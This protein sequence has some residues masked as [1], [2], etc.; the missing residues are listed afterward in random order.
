MI[1]RQRLRISCFAYSLFI[2]S[3][4][5]LAG[6]VALQR[7]P[8]LQWERYGTAAVVVFGGSLFFSRLRGPLSFCPW[9]FSLLATGDDPILAG[10]PAAVKRAGLAVI[11]L[12]KALYNLMQKKRGHKP[13]NGAGLQ[14]GGGT[15]IR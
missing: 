1:S 6:G 13:S 7:V 10:Q 12:T 8:V 5:P 4:L 15:E 2:K 9:P 11:R 14:K 3:F